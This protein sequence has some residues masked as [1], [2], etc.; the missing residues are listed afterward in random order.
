MADF[1]RWINHPKVDS[2]AMLGAFLNWIGTAP[3]E[4]QREVERLFTKD[5]AFANIAGARDVRPRLPTGVDLQSF[6]CET[7]N[8][9]RCASL[10]GGYQFK[11]YDSRWVDAYNSMKRDDAVSLPMAPSSPG[12]G[13]GLG[14]DIKGKQHD[15]PGP[16]S[17]SSNSS[18]SMEVLAY[19]NENMLIRPCVDCAR[20]TG[21][22]CDFCRAADR[23]PD[24]K[25]ADRQMTPLCTVCCHEKHHK[26]RF[27]RAETTQQRPAGSS[28]VHAQERGSGNGA[29]REEQP[30]REGMAWST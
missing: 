17:S 12:H 13:S 10:R 20:I 25:W 14:N 15:N 4:M 11:W 30:A 24:Q 22:F 18:I 7:A 8:C 21:S 19:G 6:Q 5:H 27:C 28:R 16:T 9:D 23:C 2:P 3:V 29:A 26:C 1:P